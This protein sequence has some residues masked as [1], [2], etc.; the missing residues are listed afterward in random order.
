[1][2]AAYVDGAPGALVSGVVWL[3]AAATSLALG[4]KASVWVLL[5]GGMSIFP[6]A[7]VVC[8]LMGASGKHT[9]GNPLGLLAMEGTA[10]LMAGIYLSLAVFL[11][12]TP[13]FFT[14]ML[15]VVGSRYLTF[16][17][18]YGLRAYWFA[19]GALCVV[20]FVAAAF[21]LPAAVSASFGGCIEL[22]LAAWLLTQRRQGKG[23]AVGA[24]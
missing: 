21:K 10:W 13:L 7:V 15:L 11:A 2:R 5:V 4:A 19:G 18:L 14:V 16:Q 22:G 1:M 17:T 12:G 9:K 6:L 24:P 23:H 3:A 8:R 20:G